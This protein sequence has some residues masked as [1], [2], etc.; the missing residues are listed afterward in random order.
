MTGSYPAFDPEVFSA[1]RRKRGVALGERLTAARETGSTNDDALVAAGQ[2]APHG[3]VFVTDAQTKGRGRRGHTWTSPAGQNLTFSVLLRPHLPAEQASALS[4]VAGLAVRAAAARRVR[5]PVAIKWPN[6]VLASGK[7]L[8]GILVESRLRGAEI[9]AVV[10]GV[11]VNVHMVDAPAE[12]ASVA[13]SLA[14]LGDEAPSREL[15][16]AEALAEL[17]SRLT[18]FHDVG[19]GGL[20][21]ELRQNDAL[22]DVLVQVGDVRGTAVG[23]DDRGNLLIRGATGNVH[24]VGSGTVERL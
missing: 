7:K 22:L 10:I 11:G 1:E 17:E 2:G 12:I 4:L 23:I 13:T 21:D 5:V 18:I 6:D 3:S 24:H 15:F 16:L 20:L 8:A 9:E 19:L 14:L